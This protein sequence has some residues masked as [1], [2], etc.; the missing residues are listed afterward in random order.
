MTEIIKVEDVTLHYDQRSRPTLKNIEFTVKSGER[1]L[2][3]GPSGSGKSSLTYCLNGLYPRD[4]DGKLEGRILIE[5][6]VTNEYDPGQLSQTVG[7]VFQDPE[8]QF[9]MLTVEDEIAFGLENI[10]VDREEIDVR[11]EQALDLVNM[12]PYGYMSISSLSGGWKQ[13]LSLACILA[14]QPK[15][16]V[17]DEP[18][19]NLDPVASL[20]FI[21]TIETLQRKQPFTLIV[22]E[23]KLDDWI[24]MIDRCFILNRNGELIY[25]GEPR[26]GF[27]QHFDLLQAEGIWM[28]RAFE[29]A[30]EWKQSGLIANKA[31]PLVETELV[32]SVRDPEAAIR[33]F[34]EDKTHKVKNEVILSATNLSVIVKKNVSIENLSMKLHR[35]EL[36]AIVGPN[37][38]GKSTI[39]QVL[40]GIKEPSQGEVQLY[41]KPLQ[42][43]REIELRKRVGYVF[44]NPEHQFI[45]DTVYNE[46]AFGLKMQGL[47]ENVISKKV[48]EIL[49]VCGLQGLKNQHPF[50]LSQGQKRRLSVATMIIDEQPILILDEPTFGQDAKSTKEIMNLLMSRNKLGCS[51]IM[52]THDIDLVHQYSDR[53][54]VLKDGVIHFSGHP[55]QLWEKGK[56]FLEKMSLNLPF[57]KRMVEGIR[58]R[59]EVNVS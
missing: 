20:D 50:S 10:G 27:N 32:E 2:L 31:A 48:G 13:K 3:L 17:L 4:L 43:Y 51:I 29:T 53:V 16:I 47:Q 19:A 36:L 52:V 28:P 41:D 49:E 39:T 24:T 37:G 44:Q 26:A 18:T 23:H 5:G 33:F 57:E 45:T 40:A 1:V 42:S 15:I 14:L 22:I 34:Q 56:D 35:A 7:V 11:I 38:A 30:Q 8:S 46:I 55:L 59:E 58:R 6:K 25:N 54:I 21:Q 9:C 12:R